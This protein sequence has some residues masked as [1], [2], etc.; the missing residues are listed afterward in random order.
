ML[1]C[2]VCV[3]FLNILQYL[4]YRSLRLVLLLSLQLMYKI[5]LLQHASLIPLVIHGLYLCVELSL[6]CKNTA[7]KMAM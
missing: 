3:T 1:L 6:F 2:A 5:I 4:V 7:L